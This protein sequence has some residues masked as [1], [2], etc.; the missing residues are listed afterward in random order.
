MRKKIIIGSLREIKISE[1]AALRNGLAWGTPQ[2]SSFLSAASFYKSKIC[3]QFK[4]S[5]FAF[6]IK[7]TPIIIDI[8]T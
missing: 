4:H 2:K 1:D 6:W 5:F 8:K 3:S 7:F